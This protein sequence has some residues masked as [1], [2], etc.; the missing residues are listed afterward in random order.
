MLDDR[1]AVGIDTEQPVSL[2]DLESLVH[3]RG[4]VY[5]NLR[6][7]VPLRVAERL[8]GRNAGECFARKVAQ[9]AAAASYDK[10]AERRHLADKA[11]ENRRVFGVYRDNRRA[12]GES[13]AHDEFAADYEGLLV[14]QRDFFALPDGGERRGETCVAD[15]RVHDDVDVRRCGA[16]RYRIR[17]GVYL[18][19]V[20]GESLFEFGVFRFVG[21]DDAVG[22]EFDCLLGEPLPVGT[23]GEGYYFECFRIFAY[24][25]ERLYAYRTGRAEKCDFNLIHIKLLKQYV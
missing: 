1:N 15:Q 16:L 3:E 9:R 25:V 13:L 2:D 4:R 21:Y 8:L 12:V 11:L 14:R 19:G 10:P 20:V 22:I 18:D 24:Y 7:H 17:S 5:R 6:T 23:G